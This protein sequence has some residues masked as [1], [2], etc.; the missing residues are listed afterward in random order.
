MLELSSDPQKAGGQ[1]SQ[2]IENT[3]EH[4]AC[5]GEGLTSSLFPDLEVTW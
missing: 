2:V 3:E 5:G 4:R 1:L